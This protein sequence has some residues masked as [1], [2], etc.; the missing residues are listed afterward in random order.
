[1]ATQAAE[2][3]LLLDHEVTAVVTAMRQSAKWAMVPA[4]YGVSGGARAHGSAAARG[5]LGLLPQAGAW[6]HP[7]AQHSPLLCPCGG[8]SIVLARIAMCEQHAD[9]A[10]QERE[11]LRATHGRAAWLPCSSL[12]AGVQGQAPCR[13]CSQTRHTPAACLAQATATQ[14][15]PADRAVR[16]AR[17]SRP[18]RTT[19][20]SPC[21]TTSGTCG[22]ASS[23]G[24]VC[25]APGA[26]QAGRSCTVC[27]S[28]SSQTMYLSSCGAACCSRA[29]P[30]R[31]P[32]AA[33]HADSRRR[34]VLRL[35]A[36]S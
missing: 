18:R 34:A 11:A 22:G 6:V 31:A 33:G 24:T 26:C 20:T 5:L 25:A 35:P 21:W 17:S 13:G 27:T 30:A 29:A 14:S 28:S 15:P 16:M 2:L 36:A 9:W 12:A 10:W 1:M 23:T 3:A 8:G 32:A 19:W 7:R 4:R